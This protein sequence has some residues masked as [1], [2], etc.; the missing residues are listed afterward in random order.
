MESDKRISEIEAVLSALTNGDYSARVNGA[1]DSIAKKLNELGEKLAALQQENRRSDGDQSINELYRG[2]FDNNALA[3]VIMRLS[4]RVVIDVNQACV[5]M[6]GFDGREDL[7]GKTGQELGLMNRPEV[8][9]KAVAETQKNQPTTNNEVPVKTK[10]GATLWITG[11]SNVVTVNGEPCMLI[12]MMD[13]TEKRL[14]QDELLTRTQMLEKTIKELQESEEKFQKAFH[15]SSSGNTITRIA[16]GRYVDVNEA[17]AKISGYERDELIG[18]TS[19]ELGMVVSAP[20]REAALTQLREQGYLHNQEI[21]I[22][23]KAGKQ[24]DLLFSSETISVNSEKFSLNQ[25]YDITERKQTEQQMQ[26][27]NKELEAFSYSVSHDLRAPLRILNGYS[28][29]LEED[30]NDKLDDNGRG[31]INTIRRNTIRMNSLIDNLLEFSRMGRRE[32]VKKRI[33][34]N[35]I[36]DEVLAEI[37]HTPHRAKISVARM[38]EV[39]ADKALLHQVLQNLMSNAVK[40]SSKKSDPVVNVGFEDKGAEYEFHVEDNG[41]GFDQEYAKKLFGVFQRLHTQEEFPGIGVGLAIVQRIIFRHGG[42]VWADGRRGEGAT[43]YFSLP[44]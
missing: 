41:A 5:R 15:A 34:L 35:E 13:T 16:D 27:L 4:D 33:D 3:I 10:S 24:V 20:L 19:S 18:H 29:M 8:R 26:F 25:V 9:D 7:I 44:K 14:A 30:Y 23:S 39:L 38:P 21:S 31:L 6:F 37:D 22:R 2:L 12:Q 40:Y 42:R 32:L 28:E 11:S 43:F 36:M 17:F 1:T